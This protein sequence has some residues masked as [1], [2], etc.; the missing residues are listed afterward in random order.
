MAPKKVPAEIRVYL[1]LVKE[2]RAGVEELQRGRQTPRKIQD[3]QILRSV[4]EML[5]DRAMAYLE[6]LG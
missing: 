2:Y 4:I 6:K 3:A 5:H 1:R